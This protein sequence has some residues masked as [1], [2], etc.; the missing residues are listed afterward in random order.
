M[1]ICL[2]LN[3]IGWYKFWVDTPH[4]E[5]KKPMASTGCSSAADPM[6]A[7]GTPA[8]QTNHGTIDM[9]MN[10]NT[11]VTRRHGK[12][13]W[14]LM[15][16]LL[17]PCLLEAQPA[18]PDTL[19]VSIPA[20]TI[21]HLCFDAEVLEMSGP[22][23]GA[24]F[25]QSG[26]AA[27]VVGANLQ[28][29]CLDLLPASGFLG[30][31]PDTICTVHCYQNDLQLCD[32][33]YL[34]VNVSGSGCADF[35]ASD[36]VV[37]PFSGN[38]VSVCV[39][40][41]LSKAVAMSLILDGQLYSQPLSGCDGDSLVAYS[42][43]IVPGLGNIGPYQLSS[44]EV[45]GLSFSG[46]FNNIDELV[47]LMNAFDPAG[48]WTLNALNLTITGGAS[49]S[50]Y[51]NMQIM[52][53]QTGQS[54]LLMTNFTIFFNGTLVEVIDPGIYQLVA[55]DSTTGCADS[56]H[57]VVEGQHP[58]PQVWFDTLYVGHTLA[59]LCVD[60]ADLWW[61]IASVAP[62]AGPQFGAIVPLSPDSLC[63]AYEAGMQPGVDT[64]CW[65]SCDG[66]QPA[67]CDTTYFVLAVRPRPD[68]IFLS[69]ADTLS[70]LDTCLH[71]WLE[72]NPLAADT[73]M[74][75]PTA[76]A[77]IDLA[78]V[79]TAC[80]RL[81]PEAVGTDTLCAIVCEADLCDTTVLVVSVYAAQP[82]CE[83]HFAEDTLFAEAHALPYEF[84][85]SANA[86]LSYW[87]D[88]QLVAT[89]TCPAGVGIVLEA[90]G[91]HVLVGTDP[92]GCADT[93]W[94]ELI[95]VP[96]P[97]TLGIVFLSTSVD[98]PIDTICGSTSSLSGA[99][100]ALSFCALPL[101]GS[102]QVLSD[103]CFAYLPAAG[104]TGLDSVCVTL[105]DGLTP[106]RCDS[107]RFV[108]EV[109]PVPDSLWL[110][111]PVGQPTPLYC[112]DT[113]QLATAFDTSFLCRLPQNGQLLLTGE[114]FSWVPDPGF[115]GTDT[116]CVVV[117]D[118]WGFCDTTYLFLSAGPACP[119]WFDADT[120]SALLPACDVGYELCLPLSFDSL[121]YL[122]VELD[123]QPFF[124]PFEGCMNDTFF[125]YTFFNVPGQGLAGPYQ[126]DSWT[127]NG[128]HFSGQ[129]DGLAALV[130]SMNLWDPSGNWLDSM[131]LFIFGGN[132]AQSYGDMS[133]THLPSGATSVVER[134]VVVFPQGTALTLDTGSHVLVLADT[135]HGC[136]DTLVLDLRCPD[137]CNY[138]ALSP[139]TLMVDDC[140]SLAR[141]CVDLPLLAAHNIAWT[142]N[143]QPLPDTAL[144]LC[145]PTGTAVLL[146]TGYHQLVLADT[147]KGCVDSFSL[148]VG[149]LSAN[150]ILVDTFLPQGD[151]LAFCLDD[152][153]IDTALITHL[154]ACG[155]P[156]GQIAVAY[157]TTS[158]CFVL[159]G[160]T[161]GMDTACFELLEGAVQHRIT[162]VV[163]VGQPC[164]PL[165]P[166]PF[167]G[168]G[169]DC[170]ADTS[171]YLCLPLSL[172]QMQQRQ[173]YL[174]GEP[175][176]GP[177]VGCNFDSTYSINYSLLPNGGQA[178]PYI[179]E[180]WT[181]NG[182]T[183]TGSFDDVQE[184]VDSMNLWD[185]A[186][187]WTWIEQNGHITIIG[188]LAGNV[189]GSLFVM[190]QLTGAEAVLGVSAAF[191]PQGAALYLPL[192]THELVLRDTL[193]G[194]RDTVVATVACV[195]TDTV[196]VQLE[197][198]Q[199]DTLCLST[200]EL[201]G[202]L[203]DVF[204]ACS[205]LNGEIAVYALIDSCVVIEGVEPGTDTA[206]VVLCDARGLCDT[207]VVCA[208]VQQIADTAVVAVPDSAETTTD[209][210]VIV[211]VLSNDQYQQLDTFFIL[212]PPRWGSAAWMLD[213]TIAYVPDEG[214]CDDE[215]PDSFSYVI[216]RGAQCDTAVV[217][218]RVACT[219]LVVYNGFSPNEDGIN[220]TFVIKGL[221]KFPDHHLR[222]FNR[223]G[224]LVFESTNYQ[225][226]WDGTWKGLPLPDGV[227]F[228]LLLD[229]AG[230]RYSGYV[231]ISR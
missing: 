76:S 212:D 5:A 162:F 215:V 209:E 185:P 217:W 48:N 164:D 88:G 39:P 106:Q 132:P 70:A 227:Y 166:T 69:L 208:E 74:L 73:Q 216:C 16:G 155:T 151:Q 55:V 15:W 90:Y 18:Q 101:H 140:D 107:T 179:L 92:F 36:T 122:Y 189:Y 13:L 210:P 99:A 22:I 168:A 44:W 196:C 9:E 223:W 213:G 52:Q 77:V 2:V 66:G 163:T 37:V 29:E 142:D 6:Q 183:F 72:V 24:S 173:I 26:N 57:I 118:A 117:C 138:L 35:F 111:T 93:L 229:G 100:A 120:I 112:L 110:Q 30:L 148:W 144:Q 203:S 222:I 154:A 28:G 156:A 121:L 161:P 137:P 51:G 150:E 32:T 79:D 115:S 21:T 187:Q 218:V 152:W 153:L 180:M 146:D 84:C 23:T 126:L 47:S 95:Q 160:V 178:G 224:N 94:L 219:G 81:I 64:L 129:F 125:T 136:A 49:G 19:V 62:C 202:D 109:R 3:V 27:T 113:T 91:V 220:D 63:F 68:T 139:D 34:V 43:A 114:C 108:I 188:G 228:Y 195:G 199:V 204:D 102:V 20:D 231:Q 174:D 96:P 25:C 4:E 159:D 182:Q 40:L 171:G 192:G 46:F 201:Q 1:A 169:I 56:V 165:F 131:G 78:F 147:V 59:P 128:Q 38:P 98:R 45:N 225:N 83:E 85:L 104:F 176:T 54:A 7:S 193:T 211:S 158:G 143:G 190:Q 58:V 33:T 60:T 50:Q 65:V 82:P 177:V 14:G 8:L 86:T 221:E 145:D 41:A 181:V 206:C 119:S 10:R 127:V 194:C 191:V 87:L 207:T 226:D 124:G 103:S 17:V 184:L 135:L 105:C 97:D 198:G 149:C 42:Y 31:S 133:I 214:Y 141:W 134:N 53:L 89:D 157:D 175:Y 230:N 200:A 172:M 11:T 170:M 167:A 12:Q 186:G 123:G 197:P 71:A 130:D 67:W 61:G 80:V 116:A 205:A 75:C